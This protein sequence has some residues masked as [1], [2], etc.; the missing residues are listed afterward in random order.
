MRRAGTQDAGD[1]P[2]CGSNCAV[3][4][5]HSR[6]ISRRLRDGG[7]QIEEFLA[8]GDCGVSDDAA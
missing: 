1:R 4:D 6:L 8:A 3:A 2:R 5:Y 7:V